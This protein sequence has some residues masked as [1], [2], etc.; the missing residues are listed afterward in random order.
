MRYNGSIVLRHYVT[1]Y[2]G[3]FELGRL[4]SQNGFVINTM[5]GHAC[6]DGV[7]VPGCAYALTSVTMCT[8]KELWLAE[9]D[10]YICRL[11]PSPQPLTM[12]NTLSVGLY[13]SYHG[14]EA[15]MCESQS[16]YVQL[17]KLIGKMSCTVKIDDRD[18]G[19]LTLLDVLS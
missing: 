4:V 11:V 3:D 6:R 15:F 2:H 18:P 16:A 14:D 12:Y 17:V 7:L 8:Q 1:N 13:A 9:Q 5:S 10:A 19:L